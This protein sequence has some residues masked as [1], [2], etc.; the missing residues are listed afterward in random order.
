MFKNEKY[1][2][3]NVRQFD[4]I[5]YTELLIYTHTSM[6]ITCYVYF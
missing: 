3:S 1:V 4:S 2:I 5:T 6:F